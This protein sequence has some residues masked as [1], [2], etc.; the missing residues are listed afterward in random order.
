ASLRKVS[1][2]EHQLPSSEHQLLGSKHQLLGSEH[3]LLS[4]EHQLS[5]KKQQHPLK[6]VPVLMNY[7]GRTKPQHPKTY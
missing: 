7:R 3:Q 5:S 4:S 6:F 2:F 1:K